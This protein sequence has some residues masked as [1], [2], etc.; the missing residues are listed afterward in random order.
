MDGDLAKTKEDALLSAGSAA[1]ALRH[2]FE[3]ARS[4][5]PKLSL[6]FLCKKISLHSRGHLSDL[7]SGRR[8]FQKEQIIAL[9]KMFGLNSMQL[10]YLEALHQ[11][12][13]EREP[14][15]KHQFQNRMDRLRN[16]ILAKPVPVK[17]NIH[18]RSVLEVFCAVG[19]SKNSREEIV[20]YF[21]RSRQRATEQAIEWLKENG[22]I[23]E[24]AGRLFVLS[25]CLRLVDGDTLT[26][27][28]YVRMALQHSAGSIQHWFKHPDQS[29]FE[30]NIISVKKEKYQEVLAKIRGVLA[31]SIAE[32]ESEDAD[33][34]VHFQISLYPARPPSL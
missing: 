21:G 18:Y 23:E 10:K 7:L 33:E 28:S 14:E 27:L 2:L 22:Y 20:S 11:R 4:E 13:L 25:A 31:E 32:L 12:E 34:V 6:S 5:N 16:T 1:Q 26:P 15:A 24:K 3:I 29:F 30:A 17:T 9:A 8:K 19:L